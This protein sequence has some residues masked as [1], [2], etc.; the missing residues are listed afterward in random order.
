MRDLTAQ[1]S[2][3]ASFTMSGKKFPTFKNTS[4]KDITILT[5]TSYRS[6]AYS[7]ISKKLDRT[8]LRLDKTI[9]LEIHNIFK[10]A[11]EKERSHGITS[12]KGSKQFCPHQESK[13]L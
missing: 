13:P 7:A 5:L 3:F 10:P 11:K 12:Q 1:L 2:F 9:I 4:N 8:K 6:S